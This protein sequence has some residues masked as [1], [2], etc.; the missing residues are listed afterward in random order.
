MRYLINEASRSC[1]KEFMYPKPEHSLIF[2]KIEGKPE[3]VFV[4]MNREL[5][6][7]IS[8][9]RFVILM[10]R[11]GYYDQESSF[12]SASER[13]KSYLLSLN[14]EEIEVYTMECVMEAL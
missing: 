14:K 8:W 11:M 3:M 10:E 9:A 7:R 5:V 4:D 1:G 2:Q 6:C 13:L 12:K